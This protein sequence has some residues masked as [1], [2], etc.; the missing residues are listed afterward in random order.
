MK[1]TAL[2]ER[3]LGLKSLRS[4]PAVPRQTGRFRQ[5][6]AR[7]HVLRYDLGEVVAALAAYQRKAV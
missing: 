2:Y 4:V 6:A 3:L 5:E 1:D 7:R